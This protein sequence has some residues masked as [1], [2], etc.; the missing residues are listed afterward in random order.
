MAISWGGKLGVALERRHP[1]LLDGIVLLCPGFFPKVRPSF[2]ERI[3]IVLARLH[4][5]QKL[6]AIPLNNPELFT[7]NSS[8]QRFIQEDLLSLRQ[9]TARLLMASV[10]LD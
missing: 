3:R 10:R 7:S 5:P 2:R 6:F 1:G 9:A 8:R 4:S